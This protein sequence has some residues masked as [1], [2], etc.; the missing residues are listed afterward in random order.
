MRQKVIRWSLLG[1]I[2]LILLSFHVDTLVIRFLLVG[3]LP[4]GYSS[5]PP[6]VMLMIYSITFA[7]TLVFLLAPRAQIHEFSKRAHSIK[8][9]LPQKRF[10]S[11]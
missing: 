5:L 3:E 9:R 1:S 7:L 2:V 11:L 4:G 6:I 8:S 10:N